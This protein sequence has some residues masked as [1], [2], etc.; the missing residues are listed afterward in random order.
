MIPVLEE[1]IPEIIIFKDFLKDK[2]DSVRETE[3]RTG[4]GMTWDLVQLDIG[5][6]LI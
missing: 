3:D 1:L 4:R 6:G 2:K 5:K